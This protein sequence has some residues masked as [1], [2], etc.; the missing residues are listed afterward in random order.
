M[1]QTNHYKYLKNHQ[2]PS[3]VYCYRTTIKHL[4]SLEVACHFL[5]GHRI[6]THCLIP[7]TMQIGK[8]LPY[9]AM[10]HYSL[11]GLVI[12]PN[13][14]HIRAWHISHNCENDELVFSWRT[15]ISLAFLLPSQHCYLNCEFSG[16]GIDVVW[17][18]TFFSKVKNVVSR[19]FL[20]VFVWFL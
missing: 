17:N 20:S 16:H 8:P 3:L 11:A 18:V 19:T 1:F 4:R 7:P 15:S 2:I 5:F 9:S 10:F 12:W 13:N 6:A 14:K